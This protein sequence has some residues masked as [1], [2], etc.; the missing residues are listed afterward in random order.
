MR[1][2]GLVR[3]EKIASGLQDVR[4]ARSEWTGKFVA[5][6]HSEIPTKNHLQMRQLPLN[7]ILKLSNLIGRYGI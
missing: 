1:L 5:K 4:W 2:R 6:L 3:S 7:F